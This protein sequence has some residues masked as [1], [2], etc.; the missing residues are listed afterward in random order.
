MTLNPLLFNGICAIV[1]GWMSYDNWD[2]HPHL[3]GFGVCVAIWC[4][5]DFLKALGA[6]N[7]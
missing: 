6:T 1:N 4:A 2:T 3:S 5:A 7:G